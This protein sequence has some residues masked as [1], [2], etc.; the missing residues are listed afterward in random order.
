[1]R[2]L[3]LALILLAVVYGAWFHETRWPV[4]RASDPPQ[5][6]VIAPGAGVLD[7]GRQL[8][9]L[10]LVRHPE[11][12]RLLVLSRGETGRLRAGEYELSGTMSVDQVIDKL[13]RGDVVRH[14]VTFPEGTNLEDMAR[15]VAL[16]GIP[17]AA[18]LAAARDPAPIRDVDPDAKD[19]EGYLFPDTYDIPRGPDAAA[20]LVARMVRRFRDVITPELAALK[21]GGRTP[22]QVVTLASIVELET[23]R[24][25]ER[26]RVAAVFLN[27]LQKKMPLQ[28]DPTVIY[29]L[30]QAGTYDGNIHKDDL[31]VDSPYNTYRF[32][33]LPPGPIASPG[34][35][36]LQAALHPATSR[37]LYFVSRNDGSHQFSETLAEHER[38][39]NLYQRHRGTLAM[40]SPGAST[41][42]GAAPSPRPAASP[43]AAAQGVPGPASSPAAP[44]ASARPPS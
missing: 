20:H 12:F 16:K 2:K 28:T 37:E 40:A 43:G 3:I 33:G 21:E 38:W 8:E 24:P 34:R 44:R 23:A 6:L 1:L 5:S 29:A 27:R 36:S 25:E 10:G 26:P 9:Q 19:L 18:F 13:V 11:V 41:G 14:V 4:R 39:V 42:P 31:E 30:R 15:L 7:I 35:A 17:Q 22:R 32:P